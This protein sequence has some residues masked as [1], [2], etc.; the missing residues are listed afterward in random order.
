[1]QIENICGQP[2]RTFDLRPG[3]D[4]RIADFSPCETVDRTFEST[5]PVLRFYF[6]IAASGYWEL[7][8]PYG[9]TPESKIPHRDRF[10]MIFFYPELEGKMHWP[11]DGRQFH[12]SITISPPLLNSYLGACL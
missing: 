4:L 10:S 9:N 1:M 3:M 11:A 12:I 8:S 2:S 7:R 6:H 5:N